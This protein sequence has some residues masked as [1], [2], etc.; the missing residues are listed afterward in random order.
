MNRMIIIAVLLALFAA[1][2]SEGQDEGSAAITSGTIMEV[3]VITITPATDILWGVDDPHTDEDWQVLDDAGV[4]VIEAFER[5]RNGGAG[6]NDNT[7]AADEKFRAYIDE[8]IAASNA[9]RVA[10]AAKDLDDLFEAGDALY[11]PCENCHIDY[12]PA[13]SG[14]EF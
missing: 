5:T 4:T 9:A 10:I 7:W 11:S 3:M 12:N 14:E 8:E 6:P 1:S 2:T 13:V